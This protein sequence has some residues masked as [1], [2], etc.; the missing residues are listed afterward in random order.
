MM[1][2]RSVPLRSDRRRG[3]SLAGPVGSWAPASLFLCFPEGANTLCCSLDPRTLKTT[4]NGATQLM[5][6]PWNPDFFKSF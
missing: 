4:R 6:G 2:Q 1:E 3:T 5:P